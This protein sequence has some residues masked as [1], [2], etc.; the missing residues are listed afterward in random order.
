MLSSCSLSPLSKSYESF[1]LHASSSLFESL[2]EAIENP[3]FSPYWFYWKLVSGVCLE[4]VN[5]PEVGYNWIAKYTPVL[6]VLE[7]INS[8]GQFLVFCPNYDSM[9]DKPET[10]Y[11][12]VM[13]DRLNR[14]LQ[15]IKKNYTEQSMTYDELDF[16]RARIYSVAKA[17]NFINYVQS[18]EDISV[19]MEIFHSCTVSLSKLLI[20]C[21]MGCSR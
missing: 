19:T 9:K 5:S 11:Y 8:A 3:S 18:P 13:V 2:E 1:I 20:R 14:A 12:V 16:Y 21:A 17:Y 7:K 10:E 15:V 4:L 6:L